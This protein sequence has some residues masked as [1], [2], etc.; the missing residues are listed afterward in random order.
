MSVLI[1]VPELYASAV[2]NLWLSFKI[3]M[4]LCEFWLSAL[5][6]F[7]VLQLCRLFERQAVAQV[8][9]YILSVFFVVVISHHLVLASWGL[10]VLNARDET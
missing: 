4:I 3:R 6:V 5:L 9:L 1:F 2:G 10:L 7:L 8:D